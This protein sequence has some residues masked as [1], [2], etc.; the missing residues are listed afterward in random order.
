MNPS[1]PC[2][3]RTLLRG[4]AGSAAL[5]AAS[6]LPALPAWARPVA[7]RA[8]VRAPGSLPFPDLAAGTASMPQ[9]EHVVVL[10]MENQSFDGLLGMV[11]HQVPGRSGVDGLRMRRGRVTNSNPARSGAAVR[12]SHMASPCQ[13]KG[14]PR[15]SWNASHTA[16][17]GGRNDGFVRASGPIAMR[18]W[19][20]GDLPF[21]YS[22]VRHFPIGERFFCST[23]AQTYP[24]R[25]FFFTGTASGTIATTD[26]TFGIPAA[27]G[28]IWDR[29]DA[30][31]IDWGIY[32]QS[33]PSWL[34]APASYTAAR[35]TRQRP[36]ERFF[37]DARAGRLPAFSFLDPDY[38]TTS[39]ENPQDV[40]VG[41]RLIAQVVNALLASPSW[42]STALF[43]TYDEHGGYYDHV[44][45]PP[46]IAP[47]A[48]A[49]L[50]KPGDAPGG[51]DRYGF[52]VPLIVVSPWARAAYTSRVTQ[53]LTSITAFVERKW[54]LP[55]MTL[56]DA[57]ADPMLDYFDFSRPAFA[58][59]PKLAAAPA[60]GPGLKA[61]RRQ[62]LH[63]PLPAG[64]K[65]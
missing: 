42:R 13:L 50:T 31:G 9:I 15:Q 59:P 4:A 58:R 54:N 12:A 18:C 1:R 45:P 63:P 29:L 33:A 32:Y 16:W 20:G 61:C 21:T 65:A 56:R 52:R 43:I 38:D 30:H 49:P 26:A 41:E 60:L 47:D 40:Q 19:D 55:A 25:R 57:N 14:V 35:S 28:T 53:D 7:R 44:P 48:I 34:I 17:N 39:Q 23:L 3:R 36:M 62:G 8:D 51:Y 24:N 22:L 27:N 2:T 5:L 10:I 37:T 11:P 46:A 6:Q 64:V